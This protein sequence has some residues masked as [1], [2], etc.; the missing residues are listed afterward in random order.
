MRQIAAHMDRM[1][2]SP[3]LTFKVC[4]GLLIKSV[5]DD[6]ID[7][8]IKR[9]SAGINCDMSCAIFVCP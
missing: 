7:H 9:Q 8:L 1:D 5:A 3:R 6:P 4:I 2:R